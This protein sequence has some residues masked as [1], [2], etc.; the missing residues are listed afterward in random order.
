VEGKP[1][2]VLRFDQDE[3]TRLR[4]S[5]RSVNEFTI[6]RSHELLYGV[7]ALTPCL[8]EG[9][10]NDGEHLFF[11]VISSRA[12]I[13]TLE[14]RIKVRRSVEIQPESTSK[15]L[16]F[17]T[18]SPHSTNLKERL[19]GNSSVISLSPKL[20]SHVVERL[21][22]IERNR[23]GMRAVEESLSAPKRFRGTEALQEDA[24]RTAL[25]AFGLAQD[26]AALSL[27]L[28][29]GRETAL[30][31]VAIMEDSVV[32]HDARKIPGYDLVQSDLTGRAVF[33]RRGERLEVFTANRRPLEHVF[34]VDLIYLNA[35]RQNIVMLQYKML[36]PLRRDG[37][38]NDWIY[39]P[40][41]SLDREIDRM[42]KFALAH[43]PRP[44]EY[45][46]NPA[47][48][49]FKFVKRDSLI[50]NG[51]LITPV[52]HFEKLR[53]DPACKGPKKGLRVSYNSLSGRYLRQNAFLDLIR[54]GYIGAHAETTQ[55]MTVLV[56]AVL[57]NGNAVVSAIQRPVQPGVA[58]SEEEES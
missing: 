32:E 12:A 25:K 5:R 50:S 28:V 27:E 8:I 41:A 15:L 37:A 22:S 51:G 2:V 30:A 44:H 1:I 56:E 49:Y 29:Q 26:E 43:P 16:R 4:Y 13:T 54:S 48:F 40:D 52:D 6:A 7:R 38:D 34:G 35:S 33:E 53:T 47:V 55:H 45:R 17:V 31:R 11:G 20:S 57:K 36:E 23:G 3:W 39:R 9:K 58:N 18:E 14:T 19:S 46:L 21:A 24:V 42:R 10:T